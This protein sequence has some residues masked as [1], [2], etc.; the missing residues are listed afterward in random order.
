MGFCFHRENVCHLKI[1][2][3]QKNEDVK[4]NSCIPYYRIF[5]ERRV[6]SK[7]A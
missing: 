5:I 4:P 3:L 7:F 6:F 2:M 1:I